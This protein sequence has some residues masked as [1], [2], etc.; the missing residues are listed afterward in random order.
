MRREKKLSSAPSKEMMDLFSNRHLVIKILNRFF[1]LEF[2]FKIGRVGMEGRKDTE[3]ISSD[4]VDGLETVRLRYPP[5]RLV[6]V[7]Q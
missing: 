4:T 5:H 7:I 3:P 2:R 6:V 1:T